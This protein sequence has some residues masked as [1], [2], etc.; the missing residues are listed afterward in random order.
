MSKTRYLWRS[1]SR[2]TKAD[3]E[4]TGRYITAFE[5]KLQRKLQAE[6][7]LDQAENDNNCPVRDEFEWD[8]QTAAHQHRLETARSILRSLKRVY[9]VKDGKGKPVEEREIRVWVHVRP[10]EEDDGGYVRSDAVLKDRDVMLRVLQEALRELRSFQRKW[11]EL[12]FFSE[13]LQPIDAIEARLLKAIDKR[14]EEVWQPPP[15][16][17][18]RRSNK[19]SE[20]PFL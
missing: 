12:H 5:R 11:A 8:D 14:Q 4:Q 6:D 18:V 19:F 20:H 17:A 10:T 7:L 9:I 1:G 15:P 2:H 13:I 16:G 3:A